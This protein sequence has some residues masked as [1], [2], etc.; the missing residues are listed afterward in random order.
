[1]NVY[2]YAFSLADINQLQSFLDSLLSAEGECYW[3]REHLRYRRLDKAK[4]LPPLTAHDLS[5]RL[6]SSSFEWRYERTV[7]RYRCLFT[8]ES[9]EFAFLLEGIEVQTYEAKF[10]YSKP[11]EMFVRELKH[12]MDPETFP[13]SEIVR[14]LVKEYKFCDPVGGK[15][16]MLCGVR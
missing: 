6:F 11:K 12:L 8:A 4:A 2:V 10:V 5:G 13:T 7:D 3:L 9:D 14:L 15:G 16:Y 1:M